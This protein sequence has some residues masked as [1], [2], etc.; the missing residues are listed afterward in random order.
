V[1]TYPKIQDLGK[2]A[3]KLELSNENTKCGKNTLVLNMTT[4]EDCPSKKLGLC[5]FEKVCYA[6]QAE[7]RFEKRV[8][9]YRMRQ[10]KA[11]AILDSKEITKQIVLNAIRRY[12]EIKYLRVSEC[13]DFKN[14]KDVNKLSEVAD[15]LKKYDIR[16]YT[17]TKRKDLD[18]DNVSDN[19][20]VNGSEFMLHN[21]F[22]IVDTY[23][24]NYVVCPQNCSQC[25][26][27]K[28]RSGL[29]IENRFHGVA[30][31]QQRRKEKEESERYGGKVECQ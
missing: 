15:R 23:S 19:F 30:F 9:S 1:Q 7:L 31:N 10:A 3:M 18:F 22:R 4:F 26:L 21:E 17:Y 28:T 8:L 13:G 6:K 11:W 16:V 5:V 29:I 20:V 27:C 12:Y 25:E 14:Q 2:N 24:N